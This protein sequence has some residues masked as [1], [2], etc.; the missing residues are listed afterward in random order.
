[1]LTVVTSLADTTTARDACMLAGVPG[2]SLASYE[3][4]LEQ[5]ADTDMVRERRPS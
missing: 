3:R 4:A 2:Q 1:L 5:L